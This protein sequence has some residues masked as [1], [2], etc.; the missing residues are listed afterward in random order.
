MMA[1]S[2]MATSVVATMVERWKKGAQC[3]GSQSSSSLFGCTISTKCDGFGVSTSRYLDT[4]PHSSIVYKSP[5]RSMGA[6]K[7]NGAPS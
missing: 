1:T 7:R 3:T 6:S 2:V 5:W 4:S